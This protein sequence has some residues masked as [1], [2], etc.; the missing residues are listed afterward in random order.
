M[1]YNK[2]NEGGL[3][4]KI[5]RDEYSLL[6][7]SLKLHN[8]V[9]DTVRIMQI[10]QIEGPLEKRGSESVVDDVN[11]IFLRVDNFA[12]SLKKRIIFYIFDYCYIYS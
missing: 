1:F 12:N 2:G 10:T 7:G 9:I 5:I 8:T 4:S 6:Q 3:E 11:H